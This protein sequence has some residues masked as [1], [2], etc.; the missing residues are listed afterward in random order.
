MSV[1]VYGRAPVDPSCTMHASIVHDEYTMGARWVHYARW[2]HD[3]CILH[4]G[5]TMGAFSTFFG[6][7]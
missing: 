4:D 5:Y 2:V 1:L 6:R 7:R 3:R